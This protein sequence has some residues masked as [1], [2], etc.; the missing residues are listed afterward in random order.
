MCTFFAK[1]MFTPAGID[2]Y[3]RRREGLSARTVKRLVEELGV[4]NHLGRREGRAE[5][6]R[7]IQGLCEVKWD[8][9]GM[10]DGVVE[11]R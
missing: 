3:S 9:E 8:R 5:L 2:F 6:G 1:T 4:V 11:G 7:L 10:V